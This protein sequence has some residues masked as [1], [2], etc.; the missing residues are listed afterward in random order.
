MAKVNVYGI[1]GSVKEQIDLS[2]IFQTPYRP[3]VILKSF[4]ALRAN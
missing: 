3:D 2:T 4:N 1:D